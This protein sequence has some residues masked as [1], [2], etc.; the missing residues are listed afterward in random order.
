LGQCQ[1]VISAAGL[2]GVCERQKPFE[3]IALL[4]LAIESADY[5]RMFF[6]QQ[7]LR[8]AK[9]FDFHALHVACGKIRRRRMPGFRFIPGSSF[10]FQ[11]PL[12]PG[13]HYRRIK[14]RWHTREDLL[15]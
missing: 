7:T 9:H 2:P 11:D 15:R 1:K 10:P 5:S 14:S 6:L 8:P 4:F 3:P 13:N 12:S